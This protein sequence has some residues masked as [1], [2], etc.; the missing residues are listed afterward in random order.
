[1]EKL[2]VSEIRELRTTLESLKE[3]DLQTVDRDELVDIRDVKINTELPREERLMDFVKQIKNPYCYK[4]GKYTVKVSFDESSG[5][6]LQELL[7][8]YI[9]LKVQ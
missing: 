2:N 9:Q 6:T 3:V 1:M 7:E 5:R 4:H 8:A